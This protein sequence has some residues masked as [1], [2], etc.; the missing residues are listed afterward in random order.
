MKDLPCSW[1]G[2]LN[3]IKIVLKG[4]YGFNAIVIN[5]SIV[6]LSSGKHHP[7]IYIKCQRTLNHENNLEKEGTSGNTYT[8]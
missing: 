5:V 1:F 7:K 6:F 3:I 4:I 2:R 8:S